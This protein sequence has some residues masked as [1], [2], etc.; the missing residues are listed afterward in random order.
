MTKE[1]KFKQFDI[2]HESCMNLVRSAFN[3]QLSSSESSNMANIVESISYQ[4]IDPD[5]DEWLKQKF[6]NS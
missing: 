3:G 2:E 6:P 1:E 4:P 5:Y